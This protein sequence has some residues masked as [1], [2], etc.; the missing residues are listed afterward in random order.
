MRAPTNLYE[1]D[2]YAWTQEQAN[3]QNLPLNIDDQHVPMV[4]MC[5]QHYHIHMVNTIW[6]I[7]K[8]TIQE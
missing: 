7:R 2:F 1:K 6:E 8:Y 3:L 5:R 4:N